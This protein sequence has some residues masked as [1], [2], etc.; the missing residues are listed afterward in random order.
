MR[1]LS[2]FFIFLGIGL[3]VL[4]FIIF[5]FTFYPVISSELSYFFIPDDK[6]VAT[7]KENK[8]GENVMVPVDE[9]FG[10]I[11]PKINANAK[12]IAN[13]DPYNQ[14]EYQYALTKGIAHAKGTAY[15]DQ[16]GNVFLF[17]HSSVNFYDAL[18]Y[19]SIFYLLTKLEKDDDI[20]VFY[21]KNKLKYKVKEKRIVDA[22]DVSFLQSSDAK[23]HTLTLMT[24]W[25]P[26]TTFKRLVVIAEI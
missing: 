4:S 1:K 10:I 22:K 14:N 5:V 2:S 8:K 17:A 23:A 15:P 21:N 13:V 25:P 18:R 24:C 7:S 11:I 6:I 26:G 9:D 3:I 16:F 12:V 20:Y 19:N